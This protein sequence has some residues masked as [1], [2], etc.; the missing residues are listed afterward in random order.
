[1]IREQ[2][3][4][5]DDWERVIGQL[6]VTPHST[7]IFGADLQ[8]SVVIDCLEASIPGAASVL[9]DDRPKQKAL[10][11]R[12]V[13]PASLLPKLRERGFAR[14]HV[15]ISSPAAKLSCANRLKQAGF[16]IVEVRHPT[17]SISP[18]ATI[19]EGCFFGPL[20]LVGPQAAIGPYVQVNNGASVA[21]HARVG[22][23]A[24]LSDGVRIAGRV[25]I[26]ERAFLGLGVTVNEN[27]SIGADTVIVSGVNVFNDVPADMTVRTDGKAYPNRPRRNA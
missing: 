16:A 24:R 13:V 10:L 15:A 2:A 9:V 3:T 11:Q 1:V 21:H 19:A 4:G 12:P 6:T 25:T 26:G 22:E 8:G 7:V 14:A 18:F 23:A 27:I 5:H 20:T 17:A